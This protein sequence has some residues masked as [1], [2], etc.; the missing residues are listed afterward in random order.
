M[1]RYF[2]EYS[3]FSIYIPSK[4]IIFKIMKACCGCN[5]I[6]DLWIANINPLDTDDAEFDK[7]LQK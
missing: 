4:N 1:N 3:P 2:E 6:A 5:S 7:M